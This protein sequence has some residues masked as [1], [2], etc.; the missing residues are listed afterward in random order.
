M[1]WGLSEESQTKITRSIA[2]LYYG[3]KRN[4]NEVIADRRIAATF[5]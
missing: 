4:M 2:K 5:P 3:K 1:D